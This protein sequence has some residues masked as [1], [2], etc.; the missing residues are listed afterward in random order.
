MLQE[1]YAGALSYVEKE[2]LKEKDAQ[3]QQALLFNE[4]VIYEE[5]NGLYICKRKMQEYLELYPADKEAV[6]ENYFLQT[7]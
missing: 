7:R 3:V 6:R 5:A 2:G 4:I 1:D